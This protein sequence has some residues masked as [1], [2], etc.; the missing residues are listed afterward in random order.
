MANEHHLSI[1]RQGKEAWNAWRDTHRDIFPDLSGANLIRVDLPGTYFSNDDLLFNR[2]E[3][4]KPIIP[5]NFQKANLCSA[6][7]AYAN[8]TG[9]DF[10][11]A[12]LS[13]ANI[14]MASLA[15]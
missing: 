8:L 11:G 7:M 4:A 12:D 1:L 3:F 10:D 15:D 5:I 9:A 6:N 2:K 13:D 14:A